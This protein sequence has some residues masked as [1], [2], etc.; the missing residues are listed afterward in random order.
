MILVLDFGSQYTQLI[1]RR[2][3]ESGIYAEIVPFF[4]SIENIQKKAPKG[5]ILSGGPASVYAKDA[6][7]PNEKIFDLN[8][9][10]LGI[11]YG[12]QYLVDFFGGVVAGANEQEFGKAVLE[13]AQN[14]VIFEGVKIKSLVWMSHMDKVIEL[15][16]GFT[17]LAKSP[18]SPHCAIENGKIFGLQ[19]H[20]EVVQSE[21]GGKILENF[22][23]LVC[24]CEKTW[25]MQHFAQREIARLKEK[26][27]D[28]KVLC[29]VS[30]GVDSTV[31][32]TLLHRAIKDNLIAVF[33]DHGL[34]RKNEKERVQAMFKDLQIPL[35]TIDAKEVFLSKLKGVSEP[36]LKRKIIG[37][38][39]IEV[40][41][42]EAKKHHLKGKIEFLAQGTLYPDVIESVS[43][44]GPSKVIKTHH[45]VGGLPEW[46]DFKLIEPLRELFKDE[47]R[48]LGK[49]LG[50][51]QDFLM[52]HPFPGPGLAVRILG[53][54]SESKIKCLQEADF[55][56]IEELKK[57]NLYD[58]V[59]QAFCV[60]LNVNSVGVMGDN[61]T[62]ENAICLRAV[63]ASD[64]MTA[65]FSFLEYSFLEKVSNRITN[66]VSGINRV[67]YDITSKPPGTIEWE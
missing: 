54:I 37:E 46:M 33:V 28:A 55:I 57:A 49:E 62:Y 56:F 52:R 25:G 20:P 58:K 5:L 36:E 23:L 47:V 30:G 41:E 34:L 3:R 40:F 31:V 60:L 2:L 44:K 26:I 6:Y 64:G 4:E 1:A 32:A 10:I 43:V 19:F 11:C 42:K 45:N 51:S 21:E 17:T 18:N 50:V 35:N 65:S 7:K 53:E 13:I 29:A 24:G 38:T 8:L 22:A 61:R 14:S 63:N 9:P 66:E 16:K 15:P 48:L 39:F 27:A 67:V 12:M 59:W